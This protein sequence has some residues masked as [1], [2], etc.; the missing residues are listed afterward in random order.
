MRLH[1]LSTGTVRVKNAFMFARSGLRRQPS[2]FM[3]GPFTDP[4]PIHVWVVEHDG[5]RTLV[6]TG[7]TAGVNDIPFAALV[8][9][10]WVT[11]AEPG[12][13]AEDRVH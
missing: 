5:R 12:R 6:D 1:V 10:P 8:T 2:L 4:L 3:P 7:E 9:F 11:E 13:A